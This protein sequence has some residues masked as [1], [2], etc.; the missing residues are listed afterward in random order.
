MAI[1]YDKYDMHDFHKHSHE[2]GLFG[3]GKCYGTTSVGE[4]GQVVIPKEARE[5]LNLKQGDKLVVFGRGRKALAM[6][7]AEQLTE[8]I[9]HMIENL[10]KLKKEV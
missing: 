3:G 9:D 5:E 4:R 8:H 10:E 6:I 1:K 7:K 2:K